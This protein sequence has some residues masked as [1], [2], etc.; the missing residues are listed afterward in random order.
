MQRS[1]V[2]IWLLGNRE[3]RYYHGP[4]SLLSSRLGWR[5]P[6]RSVCRHL[7][8]DSL[9]VLIACAVLLAAVPLMITFAG[10][11][12][13]TFAVPLMAV[14]LIES[15]RRTGKQAVTVAM[16][17]WTVIA[18]LSMIALE[19]PWNWLKIIGP[20]SALLLLGPASLALVVKASKNWRQRPL[21]AGNRP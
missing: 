8:T 13:V 3:I 9:R 6:S 1:S 11:Q 16:A 5:T 10:P 7:Q 2:P 12:Y 14:F 20:M 4:A 19:T 17:V 18:W 15:W 21:S